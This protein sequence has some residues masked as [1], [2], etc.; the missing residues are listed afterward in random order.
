MWFPQTTYMARGRQ[1]VRFLLCNYTVESPYSGKKRHI[2]FHLCYDERNKTCCRFLNVLNVAWLL[3]RPIH[4]AAFDYATFRYNCELPRHSRFICHM[5]SRFPNQLSCFIHIRHR[6]HI[7]SQLYLNATPHNY[8]WRLPCAWSFLI[9]KL[10]WFLK[11]KTEGVILSNGNITGKA[12][13]DEL[14]R[15][16]KMPWSCT[17]HI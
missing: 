4:T 8:S 15:C 9:R 12:F 16:H 14:G 7:N 3:L 6:C 17:K 10:Q 1:T 5:P 11:Q 13:S 2:F